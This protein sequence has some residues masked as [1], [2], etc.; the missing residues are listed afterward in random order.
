MVP[1]ACPHEHHDICCGHNHAGGGRDHSRPARPDVGRIV[2]PACGFGQHHRSLG[3]TGHLGVE[4]GPGAARSKRA[5]QNQQYCCHASDCAPSTMLSVSDCGFF[6]HSWPRRIQTSRFRICRTR[7]S[8]SSGTI[9]KTSE[10]AVATH[11][12]TATDASTP[13]ARRNTLNSRSESAT[14]IWEGLPA[15][16]E[17]PA[18]LFWPRW[19]FRGHFGAF[20]VSHP[21]P[22]QFP[23]R[24]RPH[25]SCLPAYNG[26]AYAALVLAGAWRVQYVAERM[27][28]LLGAVPMRPCC[29]D[30]VRRRKSCKAR[31]DVADASGDLRGRLME[32]GIL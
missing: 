29:F 17:R 30:S 14:W 23:S 12:T 32:S 10:A 20:L 9:P 2:S 26:L 4:V 31:C 22:H 21:P 5:E 7:R 13:S 25:R 11:R 6:S 16:R 1:N 24:K 19:R 15:I 18:G 28:G 3:P 27:A 8:R